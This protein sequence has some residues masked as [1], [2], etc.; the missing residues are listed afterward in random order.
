MSHRAVIIRCVGYG[1]AMSLFCLFYGGV[2]D[3]ATTKK[4]VK[5]KKATTTQV[6]SQKKAQKTTT[7][8]QKKTK[9]TIK[10]KVVKKKKERI[11]TNPPLIDPQNPPGGTAY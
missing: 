10:K 3:A 9:K 2:A 4:A 8:S 6:I 5:Q 7:L 1:I 11:I